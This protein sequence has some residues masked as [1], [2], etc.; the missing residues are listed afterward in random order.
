MTIGRYRWDLYDAAFIALGV[1][2]IVFEAIIRPHVFD[3]ADMLG[4]FLIGCGAWPKEAE[5]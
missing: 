4:L 5:R 1:L 3:G 2:A